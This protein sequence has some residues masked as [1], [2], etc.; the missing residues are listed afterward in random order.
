L[1]EKYKCPVCT[2]EYVDPTKALN[3][4]ENNGYPQIKYKIGQ[5][6]ICRFKEMAI[7]GTII[8]I[9]CSKPSTEYRKAHTVIYSIQIEKINGEKP[10]IT[11]AT[12]AT[13]DEIMLLPNNE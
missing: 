11:G 1:A 5:R 4:A 12:T 3:C 8:A 2:E 7:Q 6:V 9:I 10:Q 13:E